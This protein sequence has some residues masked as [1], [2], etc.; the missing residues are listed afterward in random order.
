MML[1]FKALYQLLLKPQQLC[2]L[3]NKMIGL[4]LPHTDM[5]LLS[6]ILYKNQPFL[7]CERIQQPPLQRARSQAKKRKC[8]KPRSSAGQSTVLP[9]N[10][11][12]KVVRADVTYFFLHSDYMA[13][14]ERR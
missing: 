1:V 6:T 11:Q 10:G 4:D 12:A 13:G 14:L 2:Q 3:T 9:A 7:A 8:Y 5:V